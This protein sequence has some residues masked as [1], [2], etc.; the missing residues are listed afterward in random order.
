V[1][2]VVVDRRDTLC[3]LPTGYGKSLIYQLLPFV[4]NALCNEDAA[5]SVILISPLNALMVDQISKLRQHM[6]VS[7]LKDSRK[8]MQSDMACVYNQIVRPSQIIFAHPEALLE[9]RNIF[10]NI[11]KSK[12]YQ[13]SVK[14]IVVDEAHLV[15]EW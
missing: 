14:A 10:Q 3:V 11:L 5:S 4:F 7:V 13:D 6:D 9:N 1:K 12:A 15:E 8:A 2:A